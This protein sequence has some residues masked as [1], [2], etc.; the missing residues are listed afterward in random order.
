MRM[1]S[2]VRFPCDRGSRIDTDLWWD[3]FTITVA[4]L[5][6]IPITILSNVCMLTFSHSHCS[7]TISLTRRVVTG[8]GIGRDVWTITP[9]KITQILKVYY[10]D[11]ILYLI[12]LPTIKIAILCTYL[13]IFPTKGFRTLVFITIGLNAAYAF[14]F[15]IITVFQCTP[16]S[17]VR[18]T[19]E[20]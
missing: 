1:L 6:I 12:A 18:R 17:M 10:F 20:T 4:F 14:V 16:V 9:D 5:I 8:L 15:V 13:R 19:W 7:S 11:E 2:K 3:D